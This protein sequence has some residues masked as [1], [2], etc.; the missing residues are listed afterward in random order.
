[1]NEDFLKKIICIAIK[2]VMNLGNNKVVWD[3]TFVFKYR[4]IFL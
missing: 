2:E 4:I 3:N 1:M